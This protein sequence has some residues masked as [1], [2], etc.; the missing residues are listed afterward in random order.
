M[1]QN[2]QNA[3]LGSRAEFHLFQ[4]RGSTTSDGVQAAPL[5][6]LRQGLCVWFKAFHTK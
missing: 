5:S 6:E 2:M 3:D 1:K 4:R